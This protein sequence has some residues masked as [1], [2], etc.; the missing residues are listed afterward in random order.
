MISYSIV[1]FLRLFICC[2]F[3]KPLYFFTCTQLLSYVSLYVLKYLFWLF[4]QLIATI[5]LFTI[6][7]NNL[8]SFKKCSQILIVLSNHKC[9]FFCL[10]FRNESGIKSLTSVTNFVVKKSII[11]QKINETQTGRNIF[12]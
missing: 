12:I 6:S 5:S 8:I 4:S 9:F 3:F 7:Q 11:L 2:L 10:F 1:F